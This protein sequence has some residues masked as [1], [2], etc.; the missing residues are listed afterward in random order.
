MHRT[1]SRPK[2][3]GMRKEVPAGVLEMLDFPGLRPDKV[4]TLYKVL[5]VTSLAELEQAARDDRI[6]AT[7]GLGASLQSR[8]LQ[9][10]EIAKSGETRL[11]MH[12][13]A[14]LLDNTSDRLM[15][16]QP[17]LTRFSIAGDLRRGCELVA[18]LALVAEAPELVDGPTI[19]K[20]GGEVRVHLTDP[21]HYGATLLHATGSPDHVEGLRALAKDKGFKLDELGLWKGRKL[22]A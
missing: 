20:S 2:L 19:L 16:A 11:H 6:R 17:E 7:K 22:V 15:K 13:A 21:R 3:E 9:N 10:I 8:I 18:D 5:G 12:R 14:A 4:L 1:G